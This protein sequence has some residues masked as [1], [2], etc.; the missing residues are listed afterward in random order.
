MPL[1]KPSKFN[2]TD[3]GSGLGIAEPTRGPDGGVGCVHILG[4]MTNFLSKVLHTTE[5][6]LH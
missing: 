3:H 5:I 1:T 2:I 6:I 4:S